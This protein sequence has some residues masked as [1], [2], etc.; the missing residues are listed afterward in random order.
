[1]LEG[2]Q[3]GLACSPDSKWVAVG[4]QDGKIVVW[5]LATQKKVLTLEGHTGDVHCVAWSPDGKRLASAATDRTIK[6][7]DA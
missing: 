7:W 4:R 3:A 1:M 2:F 5:E 6:I